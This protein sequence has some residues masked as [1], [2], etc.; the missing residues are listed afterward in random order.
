MLAIKVSMSLVDVKDVEEIV[1]LSVPQVY[2]YHDSEA[3]HTTLPSGL[4][5]L[6]FANKQT[7]SRPRLRQKLVSAA[8]NQMD[9]ITDNICIFDNETL[10]RDNKRLTLY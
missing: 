1:C 6:N 9:H 7:G 10:F 3:T 4:E 5:V 2:Y 8:L